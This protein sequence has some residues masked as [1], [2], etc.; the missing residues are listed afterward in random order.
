MRTFAGSRRTAPAAA[1]GLISRKR[2]LTLTSPLLAERAVPIF[3]RGE[4]AE[5]EAGFG[6]TEGALARFSRAC[7]CARS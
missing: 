7:C 1:I 3:L 2:I 4:K 5:V 6:R